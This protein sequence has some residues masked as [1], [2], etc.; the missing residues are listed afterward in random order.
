MTDREKQSTQA[1][2][3]MGATTLMAVCGTMVPAAASTINGILSVAAEDIREMGH[4]GQSLKP[5]RLYC[6]HPAPTPTGAMILHTL[7]QTLTADMGQW[8]ESRHRVAS[9]RQDAAYGAL[10]AITTM[11]ASLIDPQGDIPTDY[12]GWLANLADALTDTTDPVARIARGD[13]NPTQTTTKEQ[14]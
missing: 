12:S 4:A 8:L 7:L 5:V 6:K 9:G 11:L 3:R 1:V 13:A 14:Q 10:L 2:R